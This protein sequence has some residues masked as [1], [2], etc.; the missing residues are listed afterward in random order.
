MNLLFY[1]CLQDG[2]IL[3]EMS[4]IIHPSSA[5]VFGGVT[6]DGIDSGSLKSLLP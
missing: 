1:I 5:I 2:M 6:W 3:V 4:L